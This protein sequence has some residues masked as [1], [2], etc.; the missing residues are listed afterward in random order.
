MV[1]IKNYVS[2]VIPSKI[3]SVKSDPRPVSNFW[4]IITFLTIAFTNH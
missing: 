3:D 4:D 2:K 1:I